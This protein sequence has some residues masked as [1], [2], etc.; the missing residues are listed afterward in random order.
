MLFRKREKRGGA[1]YA[2]Q[3]G[4]VARDGEEFRSVAG[5]THPQFYQIEYDMM[6]KGSVCKRRGETVRQY[7]V[8]V[9]GA[10]RL[11]TSGDTVDRQTYQALLRAGA[12]RPP[13][14]TFEEAALPHAPPLVVDHAGFDSGKE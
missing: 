8:T 13:C 9:N 2:Q 14:S 7:G 12:I 3:A 10:T 6:I 1:P 4:A 5:N 11:V